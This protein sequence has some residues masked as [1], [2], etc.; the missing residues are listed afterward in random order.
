MK[1]SFLYCF[2]DDLLPAS[3]RGGCGGNDGCGCMVCVVFVVLYSFISLVQ[4]CHS[5]V[6]TRREERRERKEAEQQRQRLQD[7]NDSLSTAYFWDFAK[8]SLEAEGFTRL[9]LHDTYV[10]DKYET[11]L[12][13]VLPSGKSEYLDTPPQGYDLAGNFH[14][15]GDTTL[16]F[17]DMRMRY[18]CKN[19][20]AHELLPECS[21]LNVYIRR[22]G[23]L[24]KI[25]RKWTPETVFIDAPYDSILQARKTRLSHPRREPPIDE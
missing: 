13:I 23:Y 12:E 17:Y 22:D 6:Q 5:T 3:G 7:F 11:F 25:L 14:I 16:F 15:E 18:D 8:Q 19:D 20:K 10:T 2:M 21:E 1:G 24:D 9:T 4:M